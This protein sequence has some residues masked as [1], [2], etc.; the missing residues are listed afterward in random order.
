MCPRVSYK[1]KNMKNLFFGI[2][3]VTEERSRIRIR[4]HYSEVRI[5]GSGSAPKCHGFPTLEF[6]IGRNMNIPSVL[7]LLSTRWKSRWEN[8]RAWESFIIHLTMK[9]DQKRQNRFRS[10]SSKFFGIN[11]QFSRSLLFFYTIQKNKYYKGNVPLF[12][13]KNF[14]PSFFFISC[15]FFC[16]LR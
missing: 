10:S 8:D 2:L 6:T 7:R 12:I 4:I 16:F 3:K 9:G 5:R 15:D 14:P 13:P 11:I 1:E